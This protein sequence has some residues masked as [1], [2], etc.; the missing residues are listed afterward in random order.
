MKAY[1]FI[2]E[3]EYK[4]LK[5]GEILTNTTNWS[6]LNDTNSVGFCFFSHR[7]KNLSK[8][9][10]YGTDWLDFIANKAFAMVAV[11]MDSMKKGFGWYGNGRMTEYS[12]VTYSI[13]NVTGIYQWKEIGF[14][15]DCNTLYEVTEI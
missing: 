2:G 4:A 1:R 6:E 14:D 15:D 5:A 13:A 12:V 10:D 7:A 8:V 11:E 3:E 9:I